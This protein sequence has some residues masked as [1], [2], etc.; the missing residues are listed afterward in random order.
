MKF[1]DKLAIV[2]GGTRGIGRAIA[3]ELAKDGAD[4]VFTYLKNDDLAVSLR[5]EIERLGARAYP[6]KIDVR[7]FEK[8]EE[9][10]EKI[11]EQFNN[12]D[13]LVNNAGIIKD[14]ALAMMEK[15]SWLEV[16]DTNLNGL[17]NVTKAFIVKFMKQKSGNIINITS[18]SGIIG[19]PRQTKYAAS[20]GGIIAFTKSLAKEVAPFNV[21]V[22]AV[23][24]G[25]IETDMTASLKE[26]YLKQ[27]MPQIPLGR[28]GKPEEVAKVVSFLAG[29]ESNYITGQVIRIDGGLGM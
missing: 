22:N 23:A 26:E 4:I 28:F 24:P 3:L 20:K 6:F 2:T 29:D 15:E 21:R 18:L 7:D 16:I 11:I 27:V 12:I 10:K 9:W 14:S 13:I 1:K 19:L 25:F 17:F 5:K 8:V